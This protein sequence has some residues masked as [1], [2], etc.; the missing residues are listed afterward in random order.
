MTTVIV[1]PKDVIGSRK[2]PMS[3]VP[4]RVMSEIGLGMLEGKCK[5]G[6]YNFRGA[7]VRASIYYDG[8]M[9]HIGAWWEGEDIDPD[10]GLNHV[11]KALSDL[12]VL[13]DSMMQG[14]WTDDRPPSAAPFMEQHNKMA[15]EIIGR[16]ADQSPKHWTIA[17]TRKELPHIA[18]LAGPITGNKIDWVWREEVERMLAAA[19]IYTLSPLR[20]RKH[21]SVG[22]D[23]REVD[24]QPVAL[25][26]I[27][28]DR[29]DVQTCGAVLAYFPYVPHRQ[30]VGTLMELGMAANQ[31]KPIILATESVE[32]RQHPF[33]R[34]FCHS[35]HDTLIEAVEETIATLKGQH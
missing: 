19:D 33:V 30:S 21:G 1:N 25:N 13:R 9:R 10:S 27:E 34:A 8:L 6:G 35:A 29:L 26:E 5:H 17:D 12:V 20:G 24:G 4:F 15:A 14:N 31:H 11:A 18:Y 16:Y 3:A 7:G 28:R 23:G 32:L 2:A 22:A